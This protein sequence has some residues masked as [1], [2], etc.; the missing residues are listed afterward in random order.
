MVTLTANT[1]TTKYVIWFV[2][3]EYGTKHKVTYIFFEFKLN[4]IV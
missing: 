3:A 1:I 2:V 4:V